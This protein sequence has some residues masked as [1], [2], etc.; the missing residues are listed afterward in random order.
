MPYN[1]IPYLKC[2]AASWNNEWH[3]QHCDN[4]IYIV[5]APLPDVVTVV[6]DDVVADPVGVVVDAVV[7]DP[8]VVESVVDEKSG[9]YM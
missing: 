9:M 3:I 5:V 2:Q 1:T 4:I 7:V 8:V 6:V